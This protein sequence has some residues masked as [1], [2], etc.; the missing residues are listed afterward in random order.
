LLSEKSRT[1]SAISRFLGG[2]FMTTKPKVDDLRWLALCASKGRES[3]DPNTKVGCVIV[4]PDR[5]VR[6]EACNTYPSGVH[7]GIQERTEVPLKYVWIEH[8][9]RNAI[10]LAARRG[11][12]TE[13]CTMVV[14]LTPCVECARAIIQAGVAQVVINDDRAAEYRGDR[15]SGEHSTALAMLA[16]AGIAVRFVSPRLD[17]REGKEA[18]GE[19]EERNGSTGDVR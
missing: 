7:N 1:D 8:A 3:P 10:Y 9:E 19:R 14:E 6:S 2:M 15:Y 5:S 13:G 17:L 12:S 11:I 16:E 18:S 4:G